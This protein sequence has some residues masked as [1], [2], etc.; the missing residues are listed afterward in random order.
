MVI[1]ITTGPV[2]PLR[3]KTNP[4]IAAYST[5]LKRASEQAECN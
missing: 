3:M 5:V 2:L 4:T 1:N